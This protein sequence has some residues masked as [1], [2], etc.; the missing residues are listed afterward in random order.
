[1]PSG[2]PLIRWKARRSRAGMPQRAPATD[3]TRTS[4][5][6]ATIAPLSRTPAFHHADAPT[7][8][9]DP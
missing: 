7:A 9:I 6:A 5:P 4:T 8:M 2:Q 1:M 3:A